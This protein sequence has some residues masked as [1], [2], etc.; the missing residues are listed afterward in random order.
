MA[1]VKRYYVVE[2]QF[3][4]DEFDDPTIQLG[5]EYAGGTDD[6]TLRAWRMESPWFEVRT[7]RRI[8]AHH[9][10]MEVPV[11]TVGGTLK[12]HTR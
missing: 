7:G 5:L 4:P 1:R 6:V 10:A 8:D 2:A 9:E 11:Q 12:P 3:D